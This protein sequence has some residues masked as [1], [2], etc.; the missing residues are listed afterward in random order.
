MSKDEL[1]GIFGIG[2]ELD[3]IDTLLRNT[4][5]GRSRPM[6]KER[7][8]GESL[9]G[10]EDTLG[11]I[12]VEFDIVEG[13]SA[14]TM[15]D[16]LCAIADNSNRIASALELLARHFVPN[17]MLLDFQEQVEKATQDGNSLQILPLCKRFYTV[18]RLT[19]KENH[20]AST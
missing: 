6:E 1:E 10:I 17:E 13:E 12:G 3:S 2:R 11:K 7:S 16:N 18:W 9:A 5:I 15:A 19:K 4:L 8:V 14:F 20:N